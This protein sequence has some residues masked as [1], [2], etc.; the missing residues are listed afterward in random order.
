MSFLDNVSRALGVAPPQT[1]VPPTVGENNSNTNMRFQ[2]ANPAPNQQQQQQNL[3]NAGVSGNGDPT[4]NPQGNSNPPQGKPAFNPID[5]F[6]KMGDN[7]NA[8]QAPGFT[9]DP[10]QLEQLAKGQDFLAGVDPELLNK[11]NSG[12]FQAQM[13]VMHQAM[14]NVYQT[15][16]T[17]QSRLAET[18]VSQREAH[19][20]KALPNTIRRELAVSSLADTPNF[21]NPAV[22]T[23][24]V[25]IAKSLQAQHPDAPPEE[26][27]TMAKQAVIDMARAISP[28]QS[29]NPGQGN[30]QAQKE[31]DWNAWFD[32]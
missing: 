9:L 31:T 18:F 15:S 11:A 22:R 17:H 28:D 8:D 7:T 2:S 25:S 32:N 13:Q 21:S 20:D 10:E 27:A 5:V 1:V 4:G 16:L 19:R 30:R 29:G 26:I 3:Q 24:L 23:H 12:D 6:T 14:R